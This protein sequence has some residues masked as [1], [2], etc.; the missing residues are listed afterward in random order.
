ME[1]AD[2]SGTKTTIIV[3]DFQTFITVK[4][5]KSCI[6]SIYSFTVTSLKL[7]K[8]FS[9]GTTVLALKVAY[10]ISIIVITEEFVRN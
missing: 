4:V 6:G 7:G 9:V 2:V 1:I 5:D 8:P 3:I 10:K